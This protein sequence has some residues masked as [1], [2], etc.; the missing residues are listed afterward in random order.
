[1]T[2]DGT[3]LV[4]HLSKSF[5]PV[6][7]V[8][9]LSFQVAPGRVTGFLGPN[10][11]GKTTTLRMLLGL[12]RPDVGH[13][14]DRRAAPTPDPP[15]AAHRR[16]RAR[17]GELPPRPHGARPPAALRPAGR[18]PRR[19]RR[20]RCSSSSACPPRP[21]VGSAASRSACASASPWPRPCW[22]TRGSCCSTSPPT[23]STRRASAG[24]AASCARSPPRAAP[25]WCPA[26]CCRRSSRRSTTSSSSPAA[27]SRT[28]RRC[29]DLARMARVQVRAVSPDAAGLAAL[30]ERSGVDAH[31]RRSTRGWPTSADVDAATVGA[32]AFAAGVELHELTSRDPGPRR[33]VPPARRRCRDR[34]GGA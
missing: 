4:E 15:A 13:R 10:G 23:A 34:R 30:V 14:D 24:C 16:G 7:A 9:D 19:A 6:R 5:G 11:A 18:R 20:R 21:T 22:A 1:M 32:A 33:A 17:G 12:V 28:R 26:T 3:I 29:A 25:C 2:T 8:D 31:R 27:G